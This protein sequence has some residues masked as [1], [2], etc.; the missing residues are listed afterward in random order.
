INAANANLAGTGTGTGP[1]VYSWLPTAGLSNP[2]IADPV[3]DPAST[4]TY[5]LTVTDTYGC[6]VTDAIIITVDPLPTVDAGVDQNIGTCPNAANASINSVSTGTTPLVYSWLPTAGLSNPN[7]A[8]PVANPA[9]TTT[10]T[11]TVTDT[12]GCTV[13]DDILIA[14]DPLPTIDAGPDQNIGACPNAANAYI[15]TLATGTATLTYL[16]APANGLSNPGIVNPFAD[17]I[18]TTTYSVTVTD[19][20]GCTATDAVVITVNPLPTANAGTDQVL[21][22]CAWA[23]N[24]FLNGAGT[25]TAPLSYSWSPLTGL[26]DPYIGNPAADPQN[27]TTYTLTITDAFG[28]TATDAVTITVNNLPVVS[29]TADTAVICATFSSNLTAYGAVTY[30][31]SPGLG[32]SSNTGPNVTATPTSTTTYT[33]TGT[34]IYTCTASAQIT[35]TV[36]PNPI[37]TVTPASSAICF[38]DSVT[39]TASGAASYLW[40]PAIGLSSSVNNVVV[41]S[42]DMTTTYSITG[43]TLGCTGTSSVTVTVN[44]LP[45]V[46]LNPFSDVCL[47]DNAFTL[48]QGIPAGGIY[49]GD[50]ITGTDNFYPLAAGVGTH[51]ITYT[52]TDNNTCVNSDTQTIKVK[53]NPIMTVTPD[54]SD[55]CRGTSVV[56]FATG[57]DTYSW[58]PAGTLSDSTGSPVTATPVSS[59]T[60]YTVTGN[61]DGCTSS[62]AAIVHTYT[63]IPVYVTPDTD[64]LCP[65]GSTTLTASGAYQY[66]WQPPLGLSTNT[67]ATVVCTPEATTTYTVLGTDTDGCTGTATAVIVIFPEAFLEFTIVPEEGCTPL[68]VEFNYTPDGTLDMNTLHWDFGD[69]DT[70]A[71]VSDQPDCSYTYDEQGNY[72]VVLTATSVHGC[73]AIGSDTIIVYQTPTANFYPTPEIGRSDDP[74]IHFYDQSNNAQHWFWDFGDPASL[75]SN[76]SYYHNAVHQY[77]DT[78]SY[79]VMLVVSNIF[80]CTDTSFRTVKIIDPYYFWVPNAFTPN[81]DAMNDV[82]MGQGVGFREDGFEMSIYDRWGELIFDTKDS[83][84]AWDGL[85]ARTGKKCAGGVYVWI[86][87]II[88]ESSVQHKLKGNVT[89]VR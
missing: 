45:V 53:P 6:T 4:T 8:N 64:S 82:F 21:G 54:S 87:N 72:I 71:D 19:T 86:I 50:G 24:T 83:K 17:P 81:G 10:Y 80:N 36:N 31:W 46:T 60:I 69:T 39:H 1:L 29:V 13:T 22:A 47:N 88:D 77:S 30:Y 27:T 68:F 3:A 7:I 48:T 67:E 18:N 73:H 9:N 41:A 38:G 11:V 52:Y 43:T 74:V 2:N 44:P 84:E 28:C 23:A 65:G 5:T 57:A 56:L 51:L 42:P 61:I 25:G 12:Y 14:I 37:V 16:W 75:D 70:T 20:Y 85:N 66:I 35:I 89:L 40:M 34:D 76:T 62:V 79:M 15:N 49:S 33:V 32:L 26:S 55:I 63:T 59:S 58:S 78:G